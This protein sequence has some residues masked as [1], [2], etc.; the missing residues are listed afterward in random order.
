MA[1]IFFPNYSLQGVT[2]QDIEGSS[3][4]EDGGTTLRLTGNQWKAIDLGSYQITANTV[5]EFDFSSSAIGEVHGIGFDNDITAY[6][7]A[8]DGPQYFKVAGTQTTSGFNAVFDDYDPSEGTKAY[9]IYVG[10]HASG[11]YSNLVFAN[12]HDIASPT[13]ESVFSNVRLYEEPATPTVIMAN[14]TGPSSVNEGSPYTLALSASGATVTTWEIDWGD[15]MVEVL[16][17]TTQSATHFYADGESV[18]SITATASN[19]TNTYSVSGSQSVGDFN[20]DGSITND[21]GQAALFFLTPLGSLNAP[22]DVDLV[23]DFNGDGIFSQDDLSHLS[24]AINNGTPT[25]SFVPVQVLDVAPTLSITRSAAVEVGQVYSLMLDVTDPGEDVITQWSIDWGDN[26][27]IEIEPGS[28][29]LFTHSYT[30]TGTFKIIVTA[31]DDAGTY[32]KLVSV[33]VVPQFTAD[34]KGIGDFNQD[35][36]TDADD[37]DILYGYINAVGVGG[38]PQNTSQRAGDLFNDG[39]L[40][41]RDMDHLIWGLLGTQYGDVNLDGMVDHQDEDLIASYMGASV[42]GWE[43]GDFDGD[44]DHDTADQAVL[45]ANYGFRAYT[46]V[47]LTGTNGNDILYGFRGDDVISGGDGHDFLWGG[48]GNDTIEGGVGID[49]VGG[50]SAGDL[51]RQ[52]EGVDHDGDRI[53][54]IREV[55]GVGT[56]PASY[57]DTDLDALPDDWEIAYFGSDLSVI[58]KNTN[59]SYSDFDSDNLTDF[60][61]FLFGTNPTLDDSDGDSVLDGDEVQQGSNAL[62]SADGGIAL[63]SDHYEYITVNVYDPSLTEPHPD[64]NVTWYTGATEQWGVHLGNIFH[65]SSNPFSFQEAESYRFTKGTSHEI[66]LQHLLTK[67][68]FLDLGGVADYDWTLNFSDSSDYFVIDNNTPKLTGL[69]YNYGTDGF[70]LTQG[71]SADLHIPHFDLDIDSDNNEGTV[72]TDDEDRIEA[73]NDKRVVIHRGDRDGDGVV[74]THD[75]DG[76]AG[77]EFTPITLSLSDNLQFANASVIDLTFHYDAV[78]PVDLLGADTPPVETGEFR[79]WKAN[80]SAD[81]SD[82]AS[83]YIEPDTKISASSL[84]L[85]PGGSVTLY[86]EGVYSSPGESLIVDVDVTGELSPGETWQGTLTDKVRISSS[87]LVIHTDADNDGDIDYNRREHIHKYWGAG[88]LTV[89]NRGDIDGDSIP[90]FADGMN[91]FGAFEDTDD[92]IKGFPKFQNLRVGIPQLNNTVIDQVRFVYSDSAPDQVQRNEIGQMGDMVFSSFT[93]ETQGH[94]R[95]WLA[96]GYRRDPDAVNAAGPGDYIPSGEW[97]TAQQLDI[98]L[99]GGD[100]LHTYV[101][102]INGSAEPQTILVQL[103]ASDGTLYEDI[104]RYTPFDPEI[105]V[106]EEKIAGFQVIHGDGVSPIYGTSGRDIIY[107][108]ANADIIDAGDGD[109]LIVTYAGNDSVNAGAGADRIFAWS[110]DKIIAVDSSDIVSHQTGINPSAVSLT[111]NDVIDLDIEVSA[112]AIQA[113]VVGAGGGGLAAFTGEDIIEAYKWAYGDDDVWLAAYQHAG[114]EVR[115]VAGDNV[116]FSKWNFNRLTNP[117]TG[118]LVGMEVL[119]QYNIGNVLDAAM[120]LRKAILSK[121]TVWG[122]SDFQDYMNMVFADPK[123]DRQTF[124]QTMLAWREMRK[125]QIEYVRETTS[126][127]ASV[128]LEGLTIAFGAGAQLALAVIELPDTVRDISS[129]ANAA[130]SLVRSLPGRFEDWVD[131]EPDHNEGPLLDDVLPGASS[132]LAN[133]NASINNESVSSIDLEFSAVAAAGQRIARALIKLG[134]FGEFR[135][136]RDVIRPVINGVESPLGFIWRKDFDLKLDV[137]EFNGRRTLVLGTA[138]ET[139]GTHAATIS[140]ITNDMLKNAPAHKEYLY[141]GLNRSLRTMLDTGEALNGSKPTRLFNDQFYRHRPDIFAVYRDKNSGLLKVELHEVVSQTQLSETSRQAIQQN[142]DD[143]MAQIGRL[144][145]SLVTPVTKL[146]DMDP[147]S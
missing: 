79:I 92:R 36:Q 35:G 114:G 130:F 132:I 8:V 14:A 145:G 108:T 26:S 97:L 143:M 74:D 82:W 144:S 58:G 86:L 50:I 133:T 20:R 67:Q 16:P 38:Q 21:D 119:I 29:S 120:A 122:P 40:D 136:Y 98:E 5:L 39:V 66:R 63:A 134:D 78:E 52:H 89:V 99:D 83:F 49:T 17:G 54:N 45:V 135:A 126:L 30:N 115:G 43:L 10:H 57:R 51:V 121:A 22:W 125:R 13:A 124:D 60:E 129:V 112:S 48:E 116:L 65:T 87:G 27:V 28:T 91:L 128:Y 103:L 113:Q 104:V 88:G 105:V 94:F 77:L 11:S 25:G 61:D 6:T 123:V 110:G 62:S 3:V 7:G 41:Q 44:G 147:A 70:D 101:E 102:S 72:R 93:T 140:R 15:G 85:Q 106:T 109:D 146:H 71:L 37:I 2:G 131:D 32:T 81:R 23:G 42:T 118:G 73:T 111:N 59:G 141:V 76:V 138:Q 127:L 107:G 56:D 46:P 47:N 33:E 12:D 80:V 90:D 31:A 1:P 139:G 137:K 64:P 55:F 95:V 53:I 117:N 84:G 34:P 18:H 142:L 19:G 96:D 68:E 9:K 100:T 69:H 24:D 75:Y 4:I